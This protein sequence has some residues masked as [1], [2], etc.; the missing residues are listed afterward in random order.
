MTSFLKPHPKAASLITSIVLLLIV[1]LPAK[2]MATAQGQELQQR[3]FFI[4][5]QPES[6]ILIRDL[7]A[8]ILQKDNDYFRMEVIF[9]LENRSTKKIKYYSY[10]DPAEDGSNYKDYD[11]RGSGGNLLPGESERI[12]STMSVEGKPIVYRIKEVV[13]EDGT[14]WK[15]K[16]FNTVK[17]Q[18]ST[19]FTARPKKVNDVENQEQSVKRTVKQK[20]Q[21]API[22]AD[23]VTKIINAPSKIIDGI[24]VQTKLNELKPERLDVVESCDAGGWNADAADD[25]LDFD[26]EKFTSYEFKGR[27]FAYEVDYRLIEEKDQYEIGAT[28]GGIYVDE[29]G[30]GN[31]KLRCGE[32]E[33]KKLPEWI[34][35]L[36]KSR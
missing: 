4:E 21:T 2:Q 28:I 8:T 33:L 15:A 10:Q 5:L 35:R 16:P 13:F 26:V 29:E 25:G 12:K 23:R 11:V 27:I 14:Q 19:R 34:K 17:A 20:W 1:F 6:P 36:V 22:F 30:N 32:T 3:S 18:K 31:F 7:S 24:E 9:Y